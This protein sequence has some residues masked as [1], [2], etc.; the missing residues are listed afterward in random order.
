MKRKGK[1]E[2]NGGVLKMPLILVLDY[3]HSWKKI[4][5]YEEKYKIINNKSYIP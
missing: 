4:F 5:I 1:E 3:E 2:K